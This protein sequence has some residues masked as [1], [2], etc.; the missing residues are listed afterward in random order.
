MYLNN[1]SSFNLL[2]Q[3]TSVVNGTAKSYA[4]DAFRKDGINAKDYF[5]GMATV[6]SKTVW[7]NSYSKYF[8]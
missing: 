6:H 1:Q 3:W 4:I 8:D 2:N 7:D 5:L